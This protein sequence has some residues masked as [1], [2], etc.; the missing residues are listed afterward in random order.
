MKFLAETLEGPLR[1]VAAG[2]TAE[3]S[4]DGPA[5]LLK[6]ASAHVQCYCLLRRKQ[7]DRLWGGQVPLLSELSHKASFLGPLLRP[8]V[9]TGGL[10]L[11]GSIIKLISSQLAYDKIVPKATL[12][13]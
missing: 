9:W 8:Q 13:L 2:R 10:M 3:R 6:P 4:R 5:H 12:R 7:A 11:L 1:T